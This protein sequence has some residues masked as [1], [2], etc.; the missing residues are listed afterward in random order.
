VRALLF[1]LLLAAPA[2]AQEQE[3][4]CERDVQTGVQ[5]IL[6]ECAALAWEE[7]DAKLNAAYRDAIARVEGSPTEDLLR[8][9]QR[10]WVTFRDSACA[11]EAA[12]V[13]GGSMQPMM[14]YFCLAGLTRDRTEGLRTIAD[15]P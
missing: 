2:A 8:Q 4:D 7:E 11:A 1:M 6:N 12:L 15:Y 13:E 5:S 14:R 9:A 10:D 3:I